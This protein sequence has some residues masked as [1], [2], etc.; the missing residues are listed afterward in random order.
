MSKELP[1]RLSYQDAGL[2]NFDREKFPHN[3]GSV[4]IYEGVIPFEK[5]LAHVERRLELVPRYRQRMLRVPLN[6][7]HPLWRDDPNF[8]L[9]YHV[10]AVKLP[11]PGDDR[12]LAHLAGEFFATP[13]DRNRPLWE[14]LLVQGLSGGRTAHMAK[15]HHCMVDG[16]AGVQLL[17]ALLDSEPNARRSPRRRTERPAQPL[18]GRASLLVDALF[19]EVLELTDTAE[20]LALGLVHPT[21]LVQWGRSVGGALWAARS[22]FTSAA[23]STPWSTRLT[24]PRRLAWQRV[25]FAEAREIS[26]ALGGT[27][28]DVVL[29][30]LA[31]ALGRYLDLHGW[32]TDGLTVR[33]LIPVNVRTKE[34]EHTLGNRVSFMLAG[35][36]M[37][38]P[39][40][41][42]RFQAIHRE[43]TSL[44]KRDQAGGVDDLLRAVGRLPAPIQG[45]LGARLSAPNFLVNLI[46]TNVPGPLTPLYCLGHR[47]IDHYPWVL[48]TW[49]MG[50][51][52]AV[53]SYNEGLYY[54]LTAD[55]GVLPDLERLAGFLG[56]AFRELHE[57]AAKRERRGVPAAA[58]EAAR[59]TPVRAGKD[60]ASAEAGVRVVAAAEHPVAREGQAPHGA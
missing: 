5:Y 1:D 6:M 51:S 8:D 22:Y 18:P 12:Q 36:P 54:A 60:G 39:D 55:A 48:A 49:R 53:M 17:A 42:A 7:S 50:L 4:G 13:L 44:K 34:E 32:E 37:D 14:M 30:V 10:R 52:V 57:A 58:E 2:L 27:V 46:C 24:S 40:P 28:N 33:V 26:S 21:S 29:T 43:V 3:I 15:V 45:L 41:V 56:D 38:V 9:R 31:G 23:P 59:A 16:V 35:L 11:Q 19:E 20:R 47:L 25:P